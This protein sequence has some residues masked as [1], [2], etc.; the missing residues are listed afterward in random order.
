MQNKFVFGT[1]S[2]KISNQQLPLWFARSRN[3]SPIGITR[4]LRH[5]AR[6]GRGEETMLD[7]R[8]FRQCLPFEEKKVKGE[9][10]GGRCNKAGGGQEGEEVKKC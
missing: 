2:K 1:V 6:C 8:I 7:L 10:I 5:T 9:G 4:L 3:W